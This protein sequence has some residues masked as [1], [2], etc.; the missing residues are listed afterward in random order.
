MVGQKEGE[1]EGA[2]EVSSSERH[3]FVLNNGAPAHIVTTG[4]S[5][6]R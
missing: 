5:L 1:L 3:T 2:G 6:E 4:P